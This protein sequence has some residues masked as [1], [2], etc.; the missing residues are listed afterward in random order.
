MKRAL[1]LSM[2]LL[3][4]PAPAQTALDYRT[5]EAAMAKTPAGTAAADADLRA[6]EHQAK[7]VAH[8]TA[9]PSP[10]LPRSSLTKNR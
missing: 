4:T 1:A 6:A 2:A 8:S 5:A 9:R 7:A 3:A 10:P